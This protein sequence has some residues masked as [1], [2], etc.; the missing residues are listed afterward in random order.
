MSGNSSSRKAA[1][2]EAAKH[3][4]WR[5]EQP[6]HKKTQHELERKTRADKHVK[7]NTIF[8]YIT[9]FDN[10]AKSVAENVALFVIQYS[11]I[12]CRFCIKNDAVLASNNDSYGIML[13]LPF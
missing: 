8:A 12:Q 5:G 10:R 6:K 9:L 3:E 13:I 7:R 4:S 1:K 2:W 11:H